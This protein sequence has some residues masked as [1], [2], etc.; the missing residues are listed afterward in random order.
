MSQRFFGSFFQ[1]RSL[2]LCAAALAGLGRAHADP[3]AG[4][5]DI[6]AT[7]AGSCRW[8][9]AQDV[10]PCIKTAIAAAGLRGG[11]KVILPPGKYPIRSEILIPFSGVLVIGQGHELGFGPTT[12]LVWKGGVGGTMAQLGTSISG[13]QV[14]G[15][16]FKGIA[17]DCDQADSV[18]GQARRG[19]YIVNAWRADVD[20]FVR[21]PYVAHPQT[22]SANAVAFEIDGNVNLG[23]FHLDWSMQ[24]QTLPRGASISPI[25]TYKI[26][27][28][29]YPAG[30]FIHSGTDAVSSNSSFDDFWMNGT[31][32]VGVPIQVDWSDH[33]HF[34]VVTLNVGQLPNANSL[35]PGMLFN[36]VR[37]DL[38]VAEAP[39]G[40]TVDEYQAA[41]PIWVQPAGKNMRAPAGTIIG[42]NDTGNGVPAPIFGAGAPGRWG[43]DY[44]V[45]WSTPL[46]NMAVSN[47]GAYATQ[48]MATR[49]PPLVI[50]QQ[51]SNSLAAFYTQDGIAAGY[52]WMHTNKIRSGSY[53][54][55]FQNVGFGEA[56]VVMPAIKTGA[57]SVA[58]TGLLPN[59]V[60]RTGPIGGRPLA[61]GGCNA[62]SVGVSGATKS[63]VV[64]A[65][66]ANDPGSGFIWQGF[67]SAPGVVT[68]RLCAIAAARPA[69]SVYNVRV[70]Q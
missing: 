3:R 56:A 9:G 38:T 46:A 58:G 36:N 40:Q 68:V 33:L 64:A 37:N 59:L 55:A 54:L 25:G 49:G 18:A 20:A 47:N 1:K 65:T 61:A 62:G 31:Q 60:A 34:K 6:Y 26:D 39:G 43:D 32:A 17:F 53:D 15:S 48:L 7:Q 41:L 21:E 42:K 12:S 28:L 70:L 5:P 66:P 50:G 2:L 16:G 11:G 24:A 51:A 45:L 22:G 19:L 8:D 29:R 35:G 69:A 23:Q 13:A 4:N 52:W 44:G 30:V 67:V 27:Q 10:A 57:L 14:W 63:M